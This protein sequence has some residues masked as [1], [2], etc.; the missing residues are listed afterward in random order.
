V[1]PPGSAGVEPRSSGHPGR[2]IGTVRNGFTK[3]R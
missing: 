3:L 2:P 1:G